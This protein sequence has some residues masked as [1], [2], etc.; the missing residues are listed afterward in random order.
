MITTNAKKMMNHIDGEWVNSL[1]CGSQEEVV[2]PANGNVI[3]YA[4]SICESGCRSCVQAAKHAYQTWS[5][6]PVP[7]RAR[8]LYKYL[9][10]L[11]E[12]KE[13]LADIITT[14]NGK[15]LKDAR[16]EVQR[17]I[18]VVELA[19]ATPTLMMGESLPAI[20]GGIDGSIWRYP[21]GV[22]AGITPFNFP[23]WFPCGCFRSPSPAETRRP[24]TFGTDSYSCR[25]AC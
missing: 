4:P 16:G 15:T 21:L 8:L 25:E 10:L 7:N 22:V 2:N 24:E 6:V 19:T 5:L 9:Q 3:A 12:Q 14:E 17:G 11:Q 20:A 18:E 23:M 13:Q 1:G